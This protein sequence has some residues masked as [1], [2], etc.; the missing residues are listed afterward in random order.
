MDKVV[1]NDRKEFFLL[2]LSK[3]HKGFFLSRYDIGEV[4]NETASQ[5]SKLPIKWRYSNSSGP[6]ET[7]YRHLDGFYIYVRHGITFCDLSIFYDYDVHNQVD[8]IINK[9][10]KIKK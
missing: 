6:L 8:F 10:I 7:L 9:I 5:F 3:Y 1:S 2:E 4:P